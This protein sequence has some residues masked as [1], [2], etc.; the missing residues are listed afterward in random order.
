MKGQG[1]HALSIEITKLLFA[2]DVIVS[3]LDQTW[4][5]LLKC[6]MKSLD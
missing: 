6:L 4:R 5:R 3:V 2:D 1:S